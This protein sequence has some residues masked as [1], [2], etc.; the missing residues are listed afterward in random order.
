VTTG[1]K[2]WNSFI[3]IFDQK[4]AAH[5]DLAHLAISLINKVWLTGVLSHTLT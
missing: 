5:S 4:D 1:S 2:K 3:E